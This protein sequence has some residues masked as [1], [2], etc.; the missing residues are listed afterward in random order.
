[1]APSIPT[2]EPSEFTAGDTVKWTVS[3][4]AFPADDGWTLTYNFRGPE[5]QNVTA[6]ADGAAHAVVISAIDSDKFEPGDYA[7]AAFAVKGAE[8]FRARSGRMAVRVN[9][10]TVDQIFDPRSHVERVLDALKAMIEKKATRDQS[11]YSIEGRSLSRMSPEELLT[12]KS[13]YETLLKQ[14]EN[15]ERI[16]QGLQTNNIVRTR[17]RRPS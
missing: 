15:A 8:R 3:L 12:W 6:V 7:W 17:F 9:L 5:T 13:H 4:G 16:K 11:S 10:Q 14:E 2:R 1:M